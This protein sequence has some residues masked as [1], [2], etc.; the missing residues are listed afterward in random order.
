MMASTLLPPRARAG[1]DGARGHAAVVDERECAS[2]EQLQGRREPGEHRRPSR[3]A[4]ELPCNARR[5]SRAPALARDPESSKPRRHPRRADPPRQAVLTP[6][7]SRHRPMPRGPTA[8]CRP[9][10]TCSTVRCRPKVLAEMMLVIRHSGWAPRDHRPAATNSD[11]HRVPW[12][13]ADLEVRTR[14]RARSSR[15]G[16]GRRVRPSAGE[17]RPSDPARVRS[18]ATRRSSSWPRASS[19]RTAVRTRWTGRRQYRHR[20]IAAPAV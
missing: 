6:G 16:R 17:R 19:P 9:P 20:A 18:R 8:P 14:R 5:A 7:S 13:H 3:I 1:L 12:Q 15:A 4:L 10:P 11:P 2:V